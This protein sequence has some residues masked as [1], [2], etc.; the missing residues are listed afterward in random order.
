MQLPGRTNIVTVE[1]ENIKAILS[2]QFSD[3]GKGQESHDRAKFVSSLVA[4][5][6]L[7][8]GR[9]DFYGWWFSMVNRPSF[10][11]PPIS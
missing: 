9:R 2:T 11:A 3:F 4:E 5:V 7:V 10:A 1:P 8:P 6:T